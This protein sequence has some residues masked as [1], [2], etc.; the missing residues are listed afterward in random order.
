M[1]ASD[2]RLVEFDSHTRIDGDRFETTMRPLPGI[3]P[4]AR[5]AQAG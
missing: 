3:G 2:G 4:G 5:R 1:P